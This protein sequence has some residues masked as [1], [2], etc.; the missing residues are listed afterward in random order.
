MEIALK[1]IG[2]GAAPSFTLVDGQER[3]VLRDD[4]VWTFYRAIDDLILR[5]LVVLRFNALPVMSENITSSIFIC[6]RHM[7]S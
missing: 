7:S 3:N 6:S 5:F 4:F 1:L 2:K